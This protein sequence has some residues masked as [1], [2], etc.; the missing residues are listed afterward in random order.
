M[1]TTDLSAVLVA[2]TLEG[3]VNSGQHRYLIKEDLVAY[4]M[5]RAAVTNKE[6]IELIVMKTNRLL[7]SDLKASSFQMRI[8]NMSYDIWGRGNKNNSEQGRGLAKH[9]N[10]LY[11]N[12]VLDNTKLKTLINE[13]FKEVVV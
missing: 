2:L 3:R 10:K 9:L 6:T 13:M 1:T 5:S 7:K 8:S 4:Y 12:K 11:T